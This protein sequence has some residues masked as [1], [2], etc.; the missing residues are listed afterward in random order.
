MLH[1]VAGLTIKPQGR[2]IDI[3]EVYESANRCIED[4][5]Y[6]RKNIDNEFDQ[7]FIQ[8][9]QMAI[10]L[11][12][13]PTL[14]RRVARQMYPNNVP[15]DTSKEYF[16]RFLAIPLLD[17]FIYE[18]EF[19]FNDLS[20][21]F[22]KLLFFASAVISKT[23]N[24]DFS[25]LSDFY[26]DDLPNKDVLDLEIKLWRRVWSAKPVNQSPATLAR[27]IKECDE[28]RFP[29]LFKLLKI[30]CTLPVTSCECERSFSCMRRLRTWLRASMNM[31]RLE[32]LAIMNIH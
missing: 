5:K 10:K 32:S 13:R 29:N 17:N 4:M 30:G 18:L 21:R 11:D 2:N 9:E 28:T 26:R 7:I 31:D 23:G 27:S 6:V 15:A 16:K 25:E 19:R 22:S 24:P 1:P 12:F 14:P 3:I 8:V 20:E